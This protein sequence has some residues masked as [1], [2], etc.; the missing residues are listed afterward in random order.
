MKIKKITQVFKN[1]KE[2]LKIML[3]LVIGLS[4]TKTST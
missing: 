2:L 1:K 4:R 3:I